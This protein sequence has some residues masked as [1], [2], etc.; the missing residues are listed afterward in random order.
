MVEVLTTLNKESQLNVNTKDGKFTKGENEIIDSIEWSPGL[1]PNITKNNSVVFVD[2][3]RI[4]EPMPK[5]LD[6]AKGIITADY[7]NH[8]EK[9][10]ISALRAKYPVTVN[11]DVLNSISK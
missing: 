9:E 8:L 1:S 10:W 6:E 4:L 7:Q 5:T 11:Q 3:I 2:V